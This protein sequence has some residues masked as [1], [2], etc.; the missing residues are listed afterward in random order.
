MNNFH[1]DERIE[2]DLY[3]SVDF[4]LVLISSFLSNG[5]SKAFTDFRSLAE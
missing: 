4:T 1:K 3:N 5:L 2:P